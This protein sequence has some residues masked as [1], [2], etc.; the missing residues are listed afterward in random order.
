[1]KLIYRKFYYTELTTVCINLEFMTEY[2]IIASERLNSSAQNKISGFFLKYKYINV[3]ESNF[4]FSDTS[5]VSDCDK[6]R[7]IT[8]NSKFKCLLY[9]KSYLIQKKMN[10][11]FLLQKEVNIFII[12][13]IYL[14]VILELFIK[15][16]K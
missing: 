7:Y 10:N 16:I 15:Y 4:F 5:L 11:I 1:M 8:F 3:S 6:M 14:T 9:N 2:F 13:I 12:H